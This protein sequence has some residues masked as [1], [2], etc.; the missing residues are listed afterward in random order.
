MRSDLCIVVPV[1]DEAERLGDDL[2]ALQ[3]LRNRGASVVVVD[4]GSNDGSVSIA[5]S[6]ADL[7]VTAP[8]G[9]AAQMNAGAAAC[10]SRVL[11]FLHADTRLP[12][13]ADA[14]VR[15]ATA[16]HA[17]GRFD[18]RIDSPRLL[19]RIVGL[20]MNWRSRVTGIATGDQA[21]FVRREVFD[22]A[23]GFPNVA[24]MEDVALSRRLKRFGSPACLRE[25]V[26]TSARRWERHGPWRT[27]WLMWRLRA[28][29][30]LGADPARLAI[31][32][33]YGPR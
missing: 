29:Y 7:V 3:P 21:L 18:V 33:G 19:L 32:Y 16:D 30:A 12:D 5:R 22:A 20:A 8:R 13:D 1:L 28:A 24:L 6:Q 17:W 31:L 14:V 15:R 27:I 26:T 10:S 11:L 2:R 9:R 23:G 25:R 4:G